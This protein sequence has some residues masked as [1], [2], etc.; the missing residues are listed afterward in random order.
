MRVSPKGKI[1]FIVQGY[2]G[3]KSQRRTLGRYPIQSPDEARAAAQLYLKA[4]TDTGTPLARLRMSDA[5]DAWLR[6]HGPKLKPRTLGDY[7]IISSRIVRPVLGDKAV[8]RL[9]NR[10]S[11]CPNPLR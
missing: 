4:L 8:V 1:T 9:M 10:T 3:G 5:L 6:E 2:G 11:S 7:Q